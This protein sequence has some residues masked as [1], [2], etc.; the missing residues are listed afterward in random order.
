[1]SDSG[2]GSEVEEEYEVEAIINDRSEGNKIFHS[3]HFGLKE[4]FLVT[5]FMIKAL[6]KSFNFLYEL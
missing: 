2:S 3:N 6:M 4:P 5:I 1:M